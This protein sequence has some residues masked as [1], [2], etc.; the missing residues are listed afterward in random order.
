MKQS[1]IYNKKRKTASFVS[2]S[3]PL[4]A[5]VRYSSLFGTAHHTIQCHEKSSNAFQCKE[6]ASA[7]L[8][9]I[10]G[11]I[12]SFRLQPSLIPASCS[13]SNS[14]PNDSFSMS[15]VLYCTAFEWDATVHARPINRATLFPSESPVQYVH[16]VI[17]KSQQNGPCYSPCCYWMYTKPKSKDPRSHFRRDRIR[18]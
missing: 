8:P 2:H 15:A 9:A 3:R 16:T 1:K 7:T 13:K 18:Q 14:Q 5:Q 4:P 17:F 12:F 11:E 10:T 6:S